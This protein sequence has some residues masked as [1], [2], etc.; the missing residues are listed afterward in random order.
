MPATR[1]LMLLLLLLLHMRLSKTVP[2]ACTHSHTPVPHSI[3][4]LAADNE[5]QDTFAPAAPATC[6]LS[7]LGFRQTSCCP[8][9]CHAPSQPIPA[10]Y[11]LLP[12]ATGLLLMDGVQKLTQHPPAKAK[13]LLCRV[14]LLHSSS[15]L[16][17]SS[18]EGSSTLRANR[19]YPTTQALPRLYPAS[20]QPLPSGTQVTPWL[21]NQ[22]AKFWSQGV[23]RFVN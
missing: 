6:L 19:D 2:S 21:Q 18:Q 17:P 23:K 4:S 11:S 10:A 20:T 5:Q 7:I 14:Q 13:Q 9:G 22:R 8:F 12:A 3:R 1:R 15:T 16:K